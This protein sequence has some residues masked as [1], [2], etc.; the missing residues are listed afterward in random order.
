MCVCV[1][2]RKLKHPVCVLTALSAC[3][4]V[5]RLP[6][7]AFYSG[8]GFRVVG[9]TLVL[10]IEVAEFIYLVVVVSSGEYYEEGG[11]LNFQ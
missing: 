5:R 1:W 4:S 8:D 10:G 2:L 7:V 3:R 6:D 9:V 11:V